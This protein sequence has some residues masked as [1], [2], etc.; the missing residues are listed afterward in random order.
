LLQQAVFP[1]LA[2]LAVVVRRTR[3][4]VAGVRRGR[5]KADND[6]PSLERHTALIPRGKQ[7]ISSPLPQMNMVG[8]PPVNAGATMLAFPTELK[9]LTSRA[10]GKSHSHVHL[11]GEKGRY[12]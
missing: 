1:P 2:T 3:C 11:P 4:H 9:A 12:G 5:G 10:S 7:A 8:L 6:P